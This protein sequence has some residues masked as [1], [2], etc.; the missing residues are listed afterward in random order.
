MA[1]DAGDGAALRR[2]WDTVC[3]DA[4]RVLRRRRDEA[5]ADGGRDTARE[6]HSVLVDVLS[7]Q[8]QV[9]GGRSPARRYQLR[10]AARGA[11]R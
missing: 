5:A 8:H 6:R 10:A 9:D 2:R 3:R 1:Q 7:L 11:P 4:G